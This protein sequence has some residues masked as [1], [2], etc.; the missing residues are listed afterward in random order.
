MAEAAVT[1]AGLRMVKLL[2]GNAPQTVADLIKAT[3]VTR[4]AVSEQLNELL[5][6]GFVERDTE[7]LP[8]RGRPRHLYRA[9]DAS[10]A[11]L[12][13]SSQSLVA[14]AIWRAIREIG[15]DKLTG[16]VARRVSR[17]LAEHYSRQIKATKPV[18]R[19]RQLVD[20]FAF[21]GAV[22]DAV[23][24]EDGQFVMRKRSC[25][26]INMVD[27]NRTV[28]AVDLEMLS[29]I[30]GTPVRRISCRHDGA[31]CCTFEIAE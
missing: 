31:P 11:L 30:V 1:Q 26:F 2:V 13:A 16:E 28:C 23:V 27:D 15:G 10:L 21:E 8:G 5:A 6:S 3:G 25:P 7:R 14:P 29:T 12:F 18:D 22:V 17:F 4:T 9:T 19:L 24:E 20:L